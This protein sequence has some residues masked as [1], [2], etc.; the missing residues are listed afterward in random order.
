M[1]ILSYCFIVLLLDAGN[2]PSN[3]QTIL[4]HYLILLWH[5]IFFLFEIIGK[6]YVWQI[7]VLETANL[8]CFLLK[9]QIKFAVSKEFIPSAVYLILYAS[10]NSRVPK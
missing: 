3:R 4:L 7:G 6:K 1:A 9:K 8:I 2:Q 10:K 5:S